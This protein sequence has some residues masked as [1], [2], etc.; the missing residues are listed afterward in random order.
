MITAAPAVAP[1][2]TL[3]PKPGQ[4]GQ[5]AAVRHRRNTSTPHLQ[6][7]PANTGRGEGSRTGPRPP[8]QLGPPEA[9]SGARNAMRSQHETRARMGECPSVT[10]T[11]SH[12]HPTRRQSERPRPGPGQGPT[13]PLGRELLGR[14]SGA[15]QQ[16]PSTRDGPSPRAARRAPVSPGQP[17]RRPPAVTETGA[18]R[19]A[20]SSPT[21]PRA[22]ARIGLPKPDPS[23]RNADRSRSEAVPERPGPV[24]S[25][26]P[27]H[28]TTQP[29]GSQGRQPGGQS[30]RTGPGWRQASGWANGTSG[31][32]QAGEWT[33]RRAGAGILTQP[34]TVLTQP[35]TPGQ[36]AG[37]GGP[38]RA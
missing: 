25:H 9:E 37:P 22:P 7:Q 36:A 38:G 19:R 26:P 30:G 32:G 23:A 11:T 31:R 2:T 10:P 35:T 14:S 5:P 17:D 15:G 18:P 29:G 3:S 4:P 28:A 27:H 1:L 6:A 34:A 12:N 16:P 20:P 13:G 24:P 21:G 33:P 8:A